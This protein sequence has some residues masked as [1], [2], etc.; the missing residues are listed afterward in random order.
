[1]KKDEMGRGENSREGMRQDDGYFLDGDYEDGLGL[2][3]GETWEDEDWEGSAGRQKK[4][5]EKRAWQAQEEAK[6]AEEEK[7]RAREEVLRKAN[8][9]VARAEAIM[10][11]PHAA[12]ADEKRLRALER[13]REEGRRRAEAARKANELAR[14]KE[15]WVEPIRQ[16]EKEDWMDVL[17]REEEKAREEKLRKDEE[18]AQA[19]RL[20]QEKEKARA[21]RLRKER[22]QAQAERLRKEE[23]AQAERLRKEK[24]E[25]QAERLRKEEEQA[26]RLWEEEKQA[27][28]EQLWE[29]ESVRRERDYGEDADEDFLEIDDEEGMDSADM[30]DFDEEMKDKARQGTQVKNE[31][32]SSGG[33]GGKIV[34]GIAAALLIAGAAAYCVMAQQYKDHFFPNTQ[35]NGV[36]AGKKEVFEVEDMIS[37]A[38][39][40]YQIHIVGRKGQEEVVT[41]DDV[42]LHTVFDGSLEKILEDQNPYL[43]ALHLLK[44]EDLQVST[45][46]AYDEMAFQMKVDSLSFL[47]PQLIESGK[48]AYL[49]EYIEGTGYE[50]VPE[51]PGTEIK[52]DV[53]ME[54]LGQAMLT[55]QP[56]FSLEDKGCYLKPLP[57]DPDAELIEQRDRLN[58]FAQMTVTYTFGEEQ[59]VLN[60]DLIHKWISFDTD[61]QPVVDEEQVKAFV[62]D[63]AE[64]YDT[65]NTTRKF[66]TSYGSEIEVSG[67]FGWKIDQSAE[68]EALAQIVA[69]GESMV[70]EPEYAQEGVSRSDK[71]YGDTYAEVNLTAQHLFLYKD[72]EKIMESDFVSG[73]V[74]RGY[75]TPAGLY[76]IAY[77]QRNAVLRGPG[78]ASPVNF[79]MPFN[80]GIGFHDASWRGSFGG[81]I[82]RTNGSHGCVNMPYNAA[83]TLF[84]TVYAGMPVICYNLDGTSNTKSTSAYGGKAPAVAAPRPTAPVT[85][86]A[87]VV[88]VQPQ[89]SAPVLGNEG[90]GSMG[91]GS[92]VVPG[93]VPATEA[94]TQPVVPVT[95]E[96]PA[97]GDNSS[98]GGSVGG[99]SVPGVPATEPAPPVVPAE[100]P[101]PAAPAVP[102]AGA[103]A[104]VPPAVPVVPGI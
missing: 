91:G 40:G 11:D 68:T 29:E 33:K 98:S 42:G 49:S 21:E 81:S 54:E 59:E 2:S 76:S 50:V 77:K 41:K 3:E 58:R 65:A 4:Q 94:V 96:V 38:M 45:V 101:A 28:E 52:K 48:A 43:W 78:Y 79:W 74:A 24:E 23:Q 10:R 55:M 64:K 7:A 104:V 83:K 100:T 71:D 17:R 84:E 87:P 56:E 25:A 46:A 32:K 82:Y 36:D 1:M 92:V 102:D 15:D 26:Q 18:Q 70:R 89:P 66:T 20:L 51:D 57:G 60:G 95:P 39:D 93:D 97:G 99:G 9:A 8:E 85:P 19:E 16:E 22:E 5:E 13:A 88:P 6:A 47:D 75:T 61:N 37:S 103:G 27:E 31:K 35:I 69:E 14:M 44:D 53:L 67:T 62:E 73:N 30:P 34:G 12:V 72:G 90:G 86:T 63:L 80:G